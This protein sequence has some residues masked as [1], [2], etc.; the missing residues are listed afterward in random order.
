MDYVI[1]KKDKEIIK[2][3]AIRRNN[4]HLTPD[5]SCLSSPFKI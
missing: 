2:D 1:K 5:S 4:F 3:K